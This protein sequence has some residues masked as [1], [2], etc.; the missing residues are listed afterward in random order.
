VA[1]SMLSQGIPKRI[2]RPTSSVLLTAV[3]ALV[4]AACQAGPGASGSASPAPTSAGATPSAGATT[5]ASAGAGSPVSLTF[6][7]FSGSSQEVVP[8]QVITQFMTDNPAVTVDEMQGATSATF[9]GILAAFKATGHPTV[10]CGYFTGDNVAQGDNN[11]L[12]MPL[13]MS[14]LPNLAGI[15]SKYIQ[16]GNLGIS[17]AS[18]LIVI[19]YRT[20][21]ISTAPT[22]WLDLLDPRF[23]GRVGMSAAPTSFI[24]GGVVG[25]NKALG[26]DESNMSPAFSAIGEAAAAGQFK[27]LF[28]GNQ[29]LHDLM[30][31]DEVDIAAYAYSN[32][33]PWIAQG[34]PIATV[35]PKEGEIAYSEYVEI[36]NGSTP[37]QVDQCYKLIDKLLSPTNLAAYMALVPV[38]PTDPNIALPASVASNPV[39]APSNVANAIQTDWDA[40]AQMVSGWTDEWNRQV[41]ANL[42]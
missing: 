1:H 11:G 35:V 12:W 28:K 14:R 27:A 4:T 38:A 20:D 8:H 15:P 13:D 6:L 29:Q 39:F 19:G 26:Y 24:Y 3:L 5:S 9:P 2:A 40:E 30:A 17:W 42:K 23:K 33:A 31:Q 41:V 10:Q 25:I 36:L 34:L 32:F 16:P 37:A 7:H 21:K 22:S 18:N